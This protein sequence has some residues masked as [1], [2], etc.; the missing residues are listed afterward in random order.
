MRTG[1]GIKLKHFEAAAGFLKFL[2]KMI[3]VPLVLAADIT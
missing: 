2:Q 1:S 3:F